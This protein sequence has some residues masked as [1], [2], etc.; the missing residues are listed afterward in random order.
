MKLG[1]LAVLAMSSVLAA[2]TTGVAKNKISADMAGCKAVSKQEIAALFDRWNHSLKSGDAKQVVANY[3][4]GSVLLPTISNK[5]RFTPEEKEDYFA[6]FL[7][8]KPVGSIDL[9]HI[10]LGCNIAMDNGLYTFAY[11]DGTKHSGRYT[12]TYVW[13]GKQWLISSHHS[14]LMPEKILGKK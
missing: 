10:Q 3:A 9:S 12:F 11:A 14:S 13:D 2:C 7:I 8:H 4:P 6:H 5:P 1:L